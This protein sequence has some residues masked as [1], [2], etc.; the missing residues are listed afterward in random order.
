MLRKALFSSILLLILFP[1]ALTAEQ[2][3]GDCLACHQKDTR[4]IFL[5]WVNSKHAKSGV[6]CIT[7]HKS[8]EEAKSKKSSVEPELCARCHAEKVAQFKEGRHAVAWDRMKEHPQYQA[9][10]DPLKKAF[11]E[12]CHNIQNKCNSCHTTH[13]YNSK[14]ARE[15]EA[16][17]KCHTG[18]AGPHDEMYASSLHGTIHATDKDPNRAPSCTHCHM[19]KGT[20]NISV[21]IVYDFWGNAVDKDGKFLSP[22]D[23]QRIRKPMIEGVC[24][25]CHIPSLTVERFELADQVKKEARKVLAEAE[26]TIRELE[27]EG[28]LPKGAV[29]GRGQLY[30][31]TSRIEALYYRMF[32]FHN[33]YAWK[34]AYHFSAD[35]AHWYGWAHL[36]MSL[37]EIKEEARKLRELNKFKK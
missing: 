27:T 35:F 14:E 30:T 37:T 21:G 4:G 9:L 19:F 7:C 24:S 22:Q 31:G 2:K 34:G 36:Q 11:C 6:D 10:P 28:I 20:H 5:S 16:C 12:R 1:P 3:I 29:L 17:K 15:P 18:L 26:R 23:Q 8:H 13:A 32:Q 33:V 25:Q